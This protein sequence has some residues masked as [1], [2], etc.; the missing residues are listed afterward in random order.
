MNDELANHF[1]SSKKTWNTKTETEYIWFDQ[2]YH[3]Y[4]EHEQ[5]M[6]YIEMIEKDNFAHSL[7]DPIVN[8]IKEQVNNILPNSLIKLEFYDLGPGLPKKSIPI[9]EGANKRKIPLKYIPVDISKSFLE[10]TANEMKKYGIVS[11][12]INC[13]FE[14][15]PEHILPKND[16]DITR[17]FQIG[18]TFN[19]YRP[20]YILSLLN[21]LMQVNDFSI[22]ITEFYSKDKLESILTPYK[23]TY[24]EK[25]NWLAL[26][27][28]GF[29]KQDF[30]Y[31][32]KYRNQR[33]E[34][35][36]RPCKVIKFKHLELT[37][38]NLIVTAISYRYTEYG[39]TRNIQTHFKHF[40]MLQKGNLAIYIIK[41]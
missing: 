33:I 11:N 14:E 26:N 35:G 7:H 19:N 15:L 9:I 36:F 25:F 13:L 6:A 31:E 18:L 30:K 10:I 24:A 40:E 4:L 5:A 8:L 1:L 20:N 34:M 32:T 3:L 22:I 39:L 28:L 37:P 16:Y 21:K 38:K 41:N 17:I 12:S 29:K 23:D 27:L 2:P